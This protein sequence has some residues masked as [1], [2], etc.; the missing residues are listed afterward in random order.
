MFQALF[1][2]RNGQRTLLIDTDFRRPFLSR[3]LTPDRQRGI[4]DLAFGTSPDLRR[5]IWRDGETGLNFLPISSGGP[6]DR[7]KD[8]F[9]TGDIISTIGEL[10]EYYDFIIVD[11]NFLFL[12]LS[13]L[14]GPRERWI[15]ERR[16]TFAV[17]IAP[18]IPQSLLPMVRNDIDEIRCVKSLKLRFLGRMEIETIDDLDGL[19]G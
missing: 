6:N 11:N 18:V 9:I 15:V 16:M 7:N 10:R 19:F 8:A 3:W 2:T 12:N 14:T 1:Q 17:S 13:Y 5:Y 4:N